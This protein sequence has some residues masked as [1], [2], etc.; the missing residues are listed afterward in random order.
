MKK[1]LL[2]KIFSLGLM[3]IAGFNENLRSYVKVDTLCE[4]IKGLILDNS[5]KSAIRVPRKKKISQ[6][7]KFLSLSQISQ[8]QFAIFIS[9]SIY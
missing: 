9:A 3:P 4:G 8:S 2:D 1:G 6:H 5:I 7:Q